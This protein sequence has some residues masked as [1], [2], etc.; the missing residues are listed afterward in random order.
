M[1]FLL[2]EVGGMIE[3]HAFTVSYKLS[4]TNNSPAHLF[5]HLN[6]FGRCLNYVVFVINSGNKLYLQMNTYSVEFNYSRQITANYGCLSLH[7]AATRDHFL[8]HQLFVLPTKCHCYFNL[9]FP[10]YGIWI[11]HTYNIPL[12]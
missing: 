12:T 2:S 1:Y 6:V 4:N 10:E 9:I 8:N 7:L 11:L 3:L 5:M